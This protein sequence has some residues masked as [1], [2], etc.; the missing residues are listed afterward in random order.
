MATSCHFLPGSLVKKGRWKQRVLLDEAMNLS[1]KVSL[2]DRY[3]N[4]A[5]VGIKP[6]DLDYAVTLL[7]GF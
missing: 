7:R 3:D 5:P 1:M 4:H 2:L 6:N